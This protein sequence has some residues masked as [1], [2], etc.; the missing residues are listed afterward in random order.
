MNLRKDL[1]KKTRQACEDIYPNID[2]AQDCI[3][4]QQRGLKHAANTIA[5]IDEFVEKTD[6]IFEKATKLTKLDVTFLFFSTAMQCARQYLLSP[7]EA[8][9]NDKEA[10]KCTPGHRDEHS[11][12]IH[13]YYNPSLEEIVGN[14][15]PFDA[16]TGSKKYNLGLSG[17]THRIHTLGHDPI[18][19]WLFGTANI[20]TSTITLDNLQSFHV[21]THDALN[22]DEIAAHA[23]T[24]KIFAYTA[25][26]LLH[27]GIDGKK[28]IAI[29]IGKEAIHLRSDLK[30]K[31]SLP[32]PIIATLDSS[33]AARLCDY[34]LD[35]QNIITVGKQAVL[36]ALINELVSM[37]HLLTYDPAKEYS[38]KLFSVRT[39]KILSYSNLIATSSN[40]LACSFATLSGSPAG[41]EFARKNIDIGGLLVTIHR[42]VNDKK[43]IAEIK[44]EF[45]AKEWYHHAIA[46]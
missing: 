32:F 6:N 25:D 40:I 2:Q 15:V 4:N 24:G 27:Q 34:G 11:N 41:G 37:V 46:N 13:R 18:L 44:Q 17:P 43:F 42:I 10:A 22:R 36:A 21:K 23:D 28:L 31:E 33:L 35:M 20:A 1:E 7:F 19:G 39:R 12:R 14:P 5:N 29:S 16:I 38:Y 3:E 9:L 30:T 45:L 8:R 26:K